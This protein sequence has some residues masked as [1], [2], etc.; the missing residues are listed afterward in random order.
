VKLGVWTLNDLIINLDDNNSSSTN[1]SRT[2]STSNN[3]TTTTTT[4]AIMNQIIN[5]IPSSTATLATLA[6]AV[7]A[8][9]IRTKKSKSKINRNEEVGEKEVELGTT[10]TKSSIQNQVS[11][12]KFCS[13]TLKNQKTNHLN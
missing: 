13:L 2:N 9:T 10:P 8:T 5:K 12:F 1:I 6:T 4:P 11:Y 3:P 7:D